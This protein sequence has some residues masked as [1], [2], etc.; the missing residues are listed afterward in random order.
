M[1]SQA[2]IAELHEQMQAEKEQRQAEKEASAIHAKKIDDEMKAERSQS[3]QMSKR[4]ELME[5][6]LAGADPGVGA[7]TPDLEM[8]VDHSIF[9]SYNISYYSLTTHHW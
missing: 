7:G 3:E 4:F 8:E 5:K 9:F 1:K 6:M 2:I